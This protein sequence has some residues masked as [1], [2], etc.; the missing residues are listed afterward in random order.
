MQK[1]SKYAAMLLAFAAISA[2]SPS[3]EENG[4]G[5]GDKP[6]PTPTYTLTLASGTVTNP[7]LETAGGTVEVSFTASDTWT[8]SVINTRADSWVS[9]SPTSGSAGAGSIKIVVTA[10]TTPDERAAT[11]QIKCGSATQNIVVTQKEKDSFTAT[12]SRTELPVEGGT[13]EIV[14][15]T[16]QS[17][18]TVTNSAAEW[19]KS[20]GTKA[21]K[22][23]T[24]VFTADANEDVSKREATITVSC[25]LGTET[26]K[27]YQAAASPTMILTQ[28]S[29]TVSDKGETIKVEIRSN[30]SV[31]MQI[32]P[33]CTW[34]KE[35]TTKAMSTN[36]YYLAVEPNEAYESRTSKVT[37]TN[38]EN[39]LS[40]TV[41][42]T[43]VQKDA[44]VAGKTEYSIPTNGGSFT[45]ELGHNVEYKMDID[46]D[47]ITA[48]T[49]KAYTVD[50]L[51]F[52]VSAND[53]KAQRTGHVTFK[54]GELSQTVTVTQA[55]NDPA[56]ETAEMGVYGVS[57]IEWE[58]SGNKDQIVFRSASGD[59]QSKLMLFV[60][61]ENKFFLI[62][63]LPQSFNVNDVYSVSVTQNVDL[64]KSV[65]SELNLMVTR[66]KDGKVWLRE[67]GTENYVVMGIS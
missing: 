8:A 41:T 13:V 27:V 9:V 3:G 59:R 22:T 56:A 67:P 64:F 44:L 47:W 58:Y 26:F 42:V 31:T 20:T 45:V 36:T 33:T 48:N 15:K 11:I 7:V 55:F 51:Q 5:N 19:L 25:A 46:V 43:Q 29:Y 53:T 24:Y 35:S 57:G 39:K 63:G 12:A 38:E 34:I 2:C 37:F 1:L 16:N 32:D 30:V 40:E 50:N 18:V 49:T 60:P 23:S 61:Q 6:A 17:S 62:K 14:V 65:Y 66:V 52:N 21:L 28:N 54:S 4:G 10:N